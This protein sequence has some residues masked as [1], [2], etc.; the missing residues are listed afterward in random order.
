MTSVHSP[1]PPR[2][3]PVAIASRPC[4]L[5]STG[6]LHLE[7]L[8]TADWTKLDNKMRFVTAVVTGKLKISNRK[9]ADLVAQL[10]KVS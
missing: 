6:K 9:K 7:G 3:A 10:R 1:L 8:M 4:L 5:A 2:S